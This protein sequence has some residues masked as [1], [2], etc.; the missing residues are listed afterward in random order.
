[1][2]TDRVDGDSMLESLSPVLHSQRVPWGANV[3]EDCVV[4][5]DDLEHYIRSSSTG[6]SQSPFLPEWKQAQSN[7][8]CGSVASLASMPFRY[9]ARSRA[10]TNDKFCSS[11]GCSTVATEEA[12][13]AY[14]PFVQPEAS[15]FLR[16]ENSSDSHDASNHH[17]APQ[18]M[19]EELESSLSALSLSQPLNPDVLTVP[20]HIKTGVATAPRFSWVGALK[21]AVTG[22]KPASYNPEGCTK[23]AQCDPANSVA[24]TMNT[25]SSDSYYH[26]THSYLLR[27]G[28][29]VYPLCTL[30]PVSCSVGVICVALRSDLLWRASTASTHLIATPTSDDANA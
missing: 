3:T 24:M 26:G 2:M 7:S 19:R 15:D 18:D 1:M 10:T 29:P 27:N 23:T 16:S 13:C 4:D 6:D 25:F 11:D 8:L 21:D 14:T 30:V 9:L 17:V 20:P 28:A 5:I 22:G 12:S